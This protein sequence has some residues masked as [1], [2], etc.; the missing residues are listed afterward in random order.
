[1]A[2]FCSA[3]ASLFGVIEEEPTANAAD[4]NGGSSED[5]GKALADQVAVESADCCVPKQKK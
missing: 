1:M 4:T 5:L 2:E 3:Q